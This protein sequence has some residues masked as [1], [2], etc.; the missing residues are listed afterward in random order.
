MYSNFM[1]L[2]SG[3]AILLSS[4]LSCHT[5]YAHTLFKCFVNDFGEIYGKVQIVYHIHALVHLA[6]EVQ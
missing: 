1:L 6:D 4:S 3:I 5:Q 2:F